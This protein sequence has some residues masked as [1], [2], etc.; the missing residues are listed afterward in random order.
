M[1][2]VIGFLKIVAVIFLSNVDCF[3]HHHL[4]LE[5]YISQSQGIGKNEF[6][7]ILQPVN[8]FDA[9]D[10]R[11]WN[12]MYIQNLEFWKPN[13]PIYINIGGPFPY[14]VQTSIFKKG[15]FLYDLVNETNGAL[16]GIEHRYYG[17]NTP[18]DLTK[19]ENLKYL[20]SQ[21]ALADVA[22]LIKY[23][24]SMSNA[25]NSKVVVVGGTMVGNAGNLA[26]W[27]RLFYSDLVDAAVSVSGPVLAKADFKDFYEI[28]GENFLKYGTPGC[29]DK[30]A[31][32]FNKFQTLLSTP[33]GIKQLK[34]EDEIC[35]FVDMSKKEN[36]QVFFDNYLGF[37]RLFSDVADDGDYL[38]LTCEK[39]FNDTSFK[40]KLLQSKRDYIVQDGQDSCNN[41]DFDSKFNRPIKNPWLYQM[42][43]EFGSF[44]S[45]EEGKHPFTNCLSVEYY[46]KACEVQFGPEF[47]KKRVEDGVKTTNEMYGALHP[48][49][50]KVVFVNSEFDPY[51][52]LGVVENLSDDA[53]AFVIANTGRA[54]LLTYPDTEIKSVELKETKK[55]VKS[56][57]K[58]WIGL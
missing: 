5:G 54:T 8:H 50:T 21:Q 22:K 19:T 49:V 53:P 27:M 4:D 13:G 30:I 44:P 18:L 32:L 36:Q 25:E 58:K 12:M 3:K 1:F 51:R 40:S 2:Y 34:K 28:V 6:K 56:L 52:K 55:K 38:K 23:V 10:T 45:T 16:F 39:N 15:F 35:D 29:Y 24:K 48:N 41:Y 57:I 46:Y 37:F 14:I 11:T 33:E 42:C 26:T 47:G 31:K 17:N 9:Q 43:T 20:N 7:R